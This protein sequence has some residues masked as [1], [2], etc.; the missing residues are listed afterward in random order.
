[1]RQPDDREQPRVPDRALNPGDLCH[2]ETSD[3]TEG[4]LRQACLQARLP[5]VAAEDLL[6]LLHRPDR[7]LTKPI[8]LEP[9]GLEL[10][11]QVSIEITARP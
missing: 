1:M 8:G 11:P 6:G 9:M 10:K 3:A 7:R 4:L 2:V 5:D